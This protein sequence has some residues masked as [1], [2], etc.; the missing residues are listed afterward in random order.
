M[1]PDWLGTCFPQVYDWIILWWLILYVDLTGHRGARIKH[2]YCCCVCEIIFESWITICPQCEWALSNPLRV[3]I[4]QEVE[5]GGIQ[6]FPFPLLE[7]GYLTPL[8]SFSCYWTETASSHAF[9]GL[10][11]QMAVHQDLSVSTVTRANSS[12]EISPN[13]VYT[14]THTF[15]LSHIDIYMYIHTHIF[16]RNVW[17]VS[18]SCKLI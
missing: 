7:L 14:H 16:M 5:E 8:L 4:K 13:S 10:W 3:W 11:L 1:W 18:D 17:L 9:L 6:P 15:F 12:K 2:C